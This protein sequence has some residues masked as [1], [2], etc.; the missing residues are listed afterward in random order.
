M[1]G[2]RGP[3][4]ARVSLTEAER[5]ALISARREEKIRIKALARS[6]GVA[7]KTIQSWQ[8]GC[9]RPT[10]DQ[11]AAWWRAVSPSAGTGHHQ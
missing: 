5:S 11:L 1:I 9:R 6:L 10:T 4:S 8:M 7:P 3:V 2:D